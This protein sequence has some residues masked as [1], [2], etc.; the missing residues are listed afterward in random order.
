MVQ[1]LLGKAVADVL[2]EELTERV[3]KLKD[4]GIEPKLAI[5]RLGEEA[6]DLSYE[7]GSLNRAEKVGV[8]VKVYELARDLSQEDLEQVI[9]DI[10]QDDS[11]HGCLIFRPLPQQIDEK[12]I[13]ALLAAE[14][15]ID[16]LTDGS[17]AGIF[18]GEASGFAPCT[19]E[20]AI[21]I[22]KHYNVELNG[23]R[24]V[25]LGRSLVIGKP[26]A[27]MLLQENST[28]TI[29]H[30]RTKDIAKVAKQADVLIAA[31]GQAK[32]VNPDFCHSEQVII[33][34]GIN[35]DEEGKLTGDVDY[36]A[37]EPLV[38]AITPVPRGVGSVTTS[39]LMKHV[40][41]AAERSNE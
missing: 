40:V 6:D 21:A 23:A 24:A 33:D 5:V 37:V 26:V 14:K 15:D 38:K 7:R 22:L 16:G 39:I 28:V 29:C 30:S 35:V 32:M 9:L 1:V 18:K 20:A 10:N 27:M 36:E 17:L 25:V 13:A 3:A 19:A 31:V 12:R 2:T 8:K 11:I 41:E 34:V 4:R